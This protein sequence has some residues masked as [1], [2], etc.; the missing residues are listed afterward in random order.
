[1]LDASRPGGAAGGAAGLKRERSGSRKDR[2]ARRADGAARAAA[3]PDASCSATARSTS[4]TWA[5]CSTSRKRAS[6]GDILVVTITADKFIT[7]KRSVSFTRRYRMRQVA[8][9]EIVDYVALVNEP[10]AVPADRGARSRTSTSRARSTPTWCSTRR[11]TSSA[12]RRWSS[13]TAAASISRPARRSRRPSCR[14]SCWRRRRRRRTTRCSATTASCSA[15][16][17]TL[18]F[19]L[20]ELKAFLA[21]ASRLRVCLLGETIIDE[22]VDVSVTNLSQKSRCVAGLET[23]RIRQIGGAGIVAL[24]LAELRQPGRLLH[25][26]PARR[27]AGRTSTVTA[28]PTDRWS[29]RASS[30]ATAATGCSSPRAPTSARSA[31]GAARLRRLRSRA[32]RRLRARPARCRG[33]STAGSPRRRRAF[34]AAMAQVNSSNYGYNLP[35]KF[36]G[37]DY[38][39][40]NRTE[41]E[42][43]LHEQGLPLRSCSIAWPAARCPGA[44]GD[45]RRAGRDGH[46]ARTGSRCRR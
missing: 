43:C 29:R 46:A 10:S 21:G 28:S 26:R 20:E 37:A 34:V 35:T 41:A 1:M 4:S 2:H 42:L 40:L 32:A 25:Q 16:S 38:Y 19:T 17:R 15:I 5:T 36:A 8:A 44:V 9:L 13:A 23:A 39:S 30:I 11:R 14:T 45:R 6:L 24:H 33:S 31:I 22:W 27:D 12:K 7:K 18:G 3:R